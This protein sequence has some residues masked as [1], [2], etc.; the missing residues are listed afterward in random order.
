MPRNIPVFLGHRHYKK[1]STHKSRSFN[2]IRSLILVSACNTAIPWPALI[3]F[4]WLRKV[5]IRS[6]F[7]SPGSSPCFA[8]RER[9]FQLSVNYT[10]WID[11]WWIKR[12]G[13]FSQCPKVF[14]WK[15]FVSV[16]SPRRVWGAHFIC[17]QFWSAWKVHFNQFGELPH[18]IFHLSKKSIT[19]FPKSISCICFEIHILFY[20]FN[21]P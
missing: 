6:V 12:Q 15:T 19:W 1:N 17:R 2:Q 13:T 18:S 7:F 8:H 11:C 3:F 20:C 10:I 16:L 21:I 4:E 14:V 5:T 9:L